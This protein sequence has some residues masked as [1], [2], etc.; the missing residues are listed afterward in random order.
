MTVS[1]RRAA[2]LVP[3]VVPLVLPLGLAAAPAAQASDG[4]VPSRP[5][6]TFEGDDVFESSGLVDRGRVVYTVND[7][8]DDAVVYGVD[9]HTGRTVSR[10]TYADEVTDVEALAPGANGTVWVGDTGDNRRTRDHVSVYRVLPLDGDRPAPRYDLAYPDS[11]HDAEALLVHPRSQQV[12][13]VT[14]SPFGGTVY[15]APRRLRTGTTNRLRAFAQVPGLVTDGSF[16]PDGRHVLLRTYGSAAVY[17]F[18][19]FHPVGS[20]QLP[21]QRQGEGIS[22]STDR[23]LVSSEGVQAEVLQVRLPTR[24]TAPLA[25]SGAGRSPAPSPVPAPRDRAED[26][27]PGPRDAGDWLGIGLVAVGV[28]ALGWLTVRNSRVRGPSRR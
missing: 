7:S 22:V 6:F 20:V 14:K 17:T 25:M 13:V 23:V 11:P 5:L 28:G 16:L 12:L 15:A 19:G 26:P 18:P 9:P 21:S 3:L 8:G 10:T 2:A 4:P 24:L 27:G 1:A